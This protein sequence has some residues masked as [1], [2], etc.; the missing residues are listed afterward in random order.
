MK[1]DKSGRTITCENCGERIMLMGIDLL[2]EFFQTIVFSGK[3]K[4]KDPVSTM[5]IAAPERGKTSVVLE[6]VCES[7][8]ILTD[9][10][11]KGLDFVCQM[12][13]KATHI[14][15]NDMAVIQ[16]HSGK[17]GA[18]FYSRLLAMTE[19]G[20]RAMAGPQ[21]FS[22]VDK[23]RRGFI[24]CITSD[25]ACDHR[26]SWYRRGL[27]RRMVPF[28]FDYPEKLVLKIKEEIHNGHENGFYNHEILRV[29]DI[30]IEVKLEE[31][32]SHE[33]GALSD[34]RAEKLGELGISLLKN[35]R[36]LARAHALRRDWKKP[37]VNKLDVEFLKRID[38]FINWEE[39]ALL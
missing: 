18:Y 1:R 38:P 4:G 12:N 31:S 34:S 6:K 30:L 5:L 16:A 14:V 26:M 35:Y 2:R 7:L 13:Q 28:H 8:V 37:V 15:I 21:G 23:G 19:E 39:A 27:A 36:A 3:V 24:G 25:Q 17:A 20:I 29:P 9:C 33:I 32:V 11:G 10:T 22:S